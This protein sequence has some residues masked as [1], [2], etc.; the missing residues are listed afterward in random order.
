MPLVSIKKSNINIWDE[1]PDLD[2]ID[3]FKKLRKEEG[4]EK[5]SNIL[6]SIYYIW[7]PKSDKRDSGFTEEELIKDI[8]K[9][10]IGDKNFK[11]AE[12]EEVKEA[13]FKYCL[14]N[15]ERLLQYYENEI[16]GLNEMM[17]DWTWT[18][19]DA[20]E[21]AAAMRNYKQLL[22]EYSEVKNLFTQ[23]KIEREKMEAGYQLSMIES[24]V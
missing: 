21:K 18:K 23:E 5:S 2:V 10:L 11:W 3:V 12:Y 16:D 1:Y 22:T 9:N 15:T 24:Y 7:D 17:K 14:T 6:K 19:H 13:W 4:D 20:S 8:N